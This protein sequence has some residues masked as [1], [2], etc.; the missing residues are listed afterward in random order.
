MRFSLHKIDIGTKKVCRLPGVS[1]NDPLNN[2]WFR[3]CMNRR[4][5]DSTA[6]PLHWLLNPTSA[7]INKKMKSATVHIE[8]RV[9]K[10]VDL[11]T[12]ITRFFLKY[13]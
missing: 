12:E 11:T 13:R 4:D 8:T 2:L 9:S 7:N 5:K 1:S 10:A 6:V 3:T